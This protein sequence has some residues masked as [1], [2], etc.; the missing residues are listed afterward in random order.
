MKVI[1][2]NYQYFPD[3]VIQRLGGMAIRRVF[4][5]LESIPAEYMKTAIMVA[6]Q[7]SET[8]IIRGFGI[9]MKKE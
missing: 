8:V 4:A 6:K 1:N 7:L 9:P 3:Q 2:S 5:I